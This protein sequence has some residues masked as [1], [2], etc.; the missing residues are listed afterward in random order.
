[1]WTVARWWSE[2]LGLGPA[3]VF[4]DGAIAARLT[5]PSSANFFGSKVAITNDTI[6]VLSGSSDINST[7]SGAFYG[8][9]RVYAKGAGWQ[10]GSSNLASTNYNPQ[11]DDTTFGAT[12]AADNGLFYVGSPGYDG[13]SANTGA[14]HLFSSGGSNGSYLPEHYAGN[15]FYT[16]ALP[17][18]GYGSQLA[19]SDGHLYIGWNNNGDLGRSFYYSVPGVASGVATPLSE[20]LTYSGSAFAADGNTLLVRTT[21]GVRIFKFDA[22]G[23]VAYNEL[24]TGGG[25]N[26]HHD[27]DDGI[28]MLSQQTS[29][30]D[31][32][33]RIAF[34]DYNSGSLQHAIP[35]SELGSVALDGGYAA[36]GDTSGSFPGD[37]GTNVG[38]AYWLVSNSGSGNWS[39]GVQET[40]VGPSA[41]DTGFSFGSDVAVDGNTIAISDPGAGSAEFRDNYG[42]VYI[43]ENDSLAAVLES[44]QSGTSSFGTRLDLS[45]DSLAVINNV[46]TTTTPELHIFERG[47]GWVNGTGNR[48][49]MV[50]RVM[51][52][53]GVYGAFADIAISGNTLAAVAHGSSGSSNLLVWENTA[54]NWQT[55]ISGGL[56]YSFEA[57]PSGS[58]SY[59]SRIQMDGDTIAVYSPQNGYGYSSPTQL[60]PLFVFENTAND[61]SQTPVRTELFPSNLS[62]VSF[63]SVFDVSGN[64]I[65]VGSDTGGT[66]TEAVY[67]FERTTDWASATAPAARLTDSRTGDWGGRVAVDG[68]TVVA[69]GTGGSGAFS[70]FERQSGWQDGDVNLVSTF[71]PN[72]AIHGV[73]MDLSADTLVMPLVA[74]D[75]FNRQ[76]LVRKGPFDITGLNTFSSRP[77][78]S[79]GIAAES[80]SMSLGLGTDITLQ[81]NNDITISNAIIVD[82]PSGNG[83]NLSLHAGR[84]IL[85]N[86]SIDTDN[87]DLTLVA[88]DANANATYRDSGEAVVVIGRD[89][90]NQSVNLT[91]GTGDI[92]IHAA[93]RF[94][95]RSGD[96]GIF[97]FDA[98]TPGRFLV[99]ANSP[100]HTGAPDLANLGEDLA[101]SGRDFVLYNT[102]FNA[103]D[104]APSSLPAGSGFIYSVLPTLNVSVGNDT[105]TYGEVASAPLTLD[106]ITVGGS[107]VSGTVFGI[108]S[109]DLVNLVDTGLAGTVSVGTNTFANAGFY[110]GGITAA[111]KASVTTGS[112]YGVAVVTGAAG[113][114]TVD[115]ATL[116]VRPD[117]AT[118]VYRSADPA[119]TVA[120]TGF[121]TGDDESVIDTDVTVTSAAGITSDIGGY[122]L[123]ATGGFDNNYLFNVTGTGLL[124]IT[125]YDLQITGLTGTDRTYDATT[126]AGF[127]GTA[128]IA[129][130]GGDAVTLAGVLTATASF[131]DKNVGT[132]KALTFSGYS[133]SGAKAGN[134]NL[135]LPAGVTASITPFEL[136]LLGLT[137]L[138]RDYDR[139]TDVTLSGT[140][141]V[142]GFGDDTV[143]VTGSASGAFADKNAGI[144]KTVDIT[145]LALTGA[146]AANYILAADSGVTATINQLGL[147][148]TG[149]TADSRVYDATTVATLS[150]TAAIAPISGDTVSVEGS[151]AANFAD[152]NVG[153]AKP[154]TVSG[155]TITGADA[156]NY[157]VNQPAGLTAD[158]T[159]ADLSITGVTAG[160]RVYDATN[161]AVL[162]GIA[163]VTALGSDEL[164]VGGIG[165]GAFA[166]KNVGTAKDV[167]VTGFTLG[168]G[169]AA[170]YNLLQPA[171]LAADITPRPITVSG[172]VVDHKVYDTTTDATGTGV[173]ALSGVLTGDDA[174]LDGT[175]FAYAFPDKNVGTAKSIVISGVGIAGAD[176]ANYDVTQGDGFTADITPAD[177][178][179]SGAVAS[180][181]EYDSTTAI[182]VSGGTLN[183]VLGSDDIVFETAGATGNTADKN[184]GTAKPVTVT[185]YAVSGAGAGNYL[186]TQPA[187]LTA[188]ITAFTL[189]LAGLTGDKTYDGNTV[190]TLSYSG[191]DAVFTDDVVNIDDAAV[192]GAYADKHAGV[193]KPITITGLYAL[194]GTDAGNYVLAQPT[195]LTGTIAKRG[196]TVSGLTIADKT[197]DATTTGA[198]SGTGTFGGTIEGDDLAIDVGA[199]TVSF[200]DKNAGTD[201]AITLS[202][203]SLTGADADNYSA[204]TPSGITATI[205][206]KDL[207]LT[208]LAAQ[209][210]VYDRTAVATIT[211]T[212]AIQGAISGD[213]VALNESARAGQFADKNAGTAKAVSILGLTLDGVDA[214]NYTIT[215]P[216]LTADITRADVDVTG[217]TA[218]DRI[219]D[220]T[221]VAGLSGT[222]GLDFG[223]LNG[224]LAGA[225]D[226]GLVGTATGSFAD[227][228][229]GVAKAVTVADLTL[230]GADAGNYNLNL[231]AGLTATVS[232]ADLQVTGTTVS[233]KT[234]DATTAG[235][236]VD[237]GTI[238][239]ISGDTVVLGGSQQA[240]FDTKNVGTGKDVALTGYAITGTDAG[241]YNLLQPTG[242]TADITKADL[243]L[244][245]VVANDKIYDG[246]TTAPLGGNLDIAPLGS[247]TVSVTGSPV[248]TFADKNVGTAKAVTLTGLGIAGPDAAN[249]NFVIPSLFAD[250]T[251][252]SVTVSGLT[253]L[254][255]IY[256]GTTIAGLSGAGSLSNGVS[257][258]DLSFDVSA[259][260]GAFA[261]K[262]VGV[263]KSVTLSGN[264]L[265]GA[266]AGNYL[267]VLP[268]DLVADIDPKDLLV[269]GADAVD[270][271]YDRTIEVELTGGTLDGVVT[272][273]DTAL[274]TTAAAGT[275]AD[276]NAGEAKAVTATGYAITGTDAGN[277]TLNQP[278]G[279]DVTIT[280]KE[281]GIAGVEVTDKFFNG[282]TDATI[283]G[284]TL[285]G[286]IAGDDLALVTGNGQGEYIDPEVGLDKPVTLSGFTLSGADAD[287]YKLPAIPETTG[288]ILQPLRVITDVVPA[289]VLR[290]SSNDSVAKQRAALESFNASQNDLVT[291]V[292]YEAF[293]DQVS[294]GIVVTKPIQ[295]IL[296][297]PPEKQDSVTK[298]YIAA[299]TESK[300]ATQ[301][302]QNM[303][304]EYRSFARTY[305][306]LGQTINAVERSLQTEIGLRDTFVA[307][308]ARVDVELAKVNE[309]LTIITEAKRRIE[310]FTQRMAEANRLG[311]GSEAAEYQ[312]VIDEARGI[313]AT[314]TAT[315][316]QKAALEAEAKESHDQ[317]AASDE[318]VAALNTEKSDLTQKIAETETGLANL[319]A[320]A[321]DGKKRAATAAEALAAAQAAG[322]K[323]YAERAANLAAEKAKVEQEVTG[324]KALYESD[325]AATTAAKLVDKDPVVQLY[326]GK[327][328]ESKQVTGT[329]GSALAEN[330]SGDTL[331]YAQKLADKINSGGLLDTA[332]E[333]RDSLVQTVPALKELQAKAD[334]L[335]KLQEDKRA[336]F[337]RRIQLDVDTATLG[338]EV[339]GNGAELSPER[340]AEIAAETRA[341][342]DA[343][344]AVLT[345]GALDLSK[346]PATKADG[347]PLSEME[348][349]SIAIINSQIYSKEGQDQAAGDFAS[350][351]SNK[352]NSA[353]AAELGF[354]PEQA[355]NDPNVLVK[356]AAERLPFSNG[357]LDKDQ[358]ATNLKDTASAYVRLNSVLKDEALNQAAEQDP[359]GSLAAYQNV[360]ASARAEFEK[361]YGAQPEE[362][363]LQ[364][365]QERIDT[366]SKADSPEAFMKLYAEDYIGPGGQMSLAAAKKAY[367][368]IKNGDNPV[369]IIKSINADSGPEG[370]SANTE[371]ARAG[372]TALA[373]RE[374]RDAAIEDADRTGL[375]KSY[376][377]VNG[378]ASEEFAKTFGGSPEE[379]ALDALE[380]PAAAAEKA[381]S[382]AKDVLTTPDGALN[383]GKL[384]IST[385]SNMASATLAVAQQQLDVV[386]AK[387]GGPGKAAAFV[388]KYGI[389][390][391]SEAKDVLQDLG[392]TLTGGLIGKSGPS[393][394][395][396]EN[397]IAYAKAQAEVQAAQRQ[398]DEDDF[399]LSYLAAAQEMAQVKTQ[400]AVGVMNAKAQVGAYV[401]A[402]KQQ[403]D[404]QTYYDT[405]K[406]TSQEALTKV[407]A[408]GIYDNLR[409]ARQKSDELGQSPEE[410]A[411][412]A[413]LWK[414]EA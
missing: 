125:P 314:E 168:G 12:F 11:A 217:L 146:D 323:A 369:D 235:T 187:G 196:I 107:A 10:N 25:F 273:D 197:Y 342:L 274:V 226:I 19:A 263:N 376:N 348:R 231:P 34:F 292:D 71:T 96:T 409:T 377:A 2:H 393:K 237:T 192:T 210:K 266:D 116:N 386:A 316:A 78:D 400:L 230:G 330:L 77:G 159:A 359:T 358:L 216:G 380:N 132:D 135:L 92:I 276:K 52:S 18:A 291:L 363:V 176:A 76:A 385:A 90:L 114:L 186:L 240:V 331:G 167:T 242:V 119:F 344:L 297:T 356:E 68:D 24:N 127:T 333:M 23:N 254:D 26:N 221:T 248:A 153:T 62:D 108:S 228:N 269:I 139:T 355:L 383:V 170:N 270:R 89:S 379:L 390:A 178:S 303:A 324:L 150:G 4:E 351:Y 268:F 322:Q 134:Y 75:G 27:V 300:A 163:G 366:Y 306:E 375:L 82:N 250:I 13:S 101:I 399:L 258:D 371:A 211:G 257:G 384:G 16:N 198:I 308:L 58:T 206:A 42:Y 405:A 46:A 255:R 32:S 54:G 318:K 172:L 262:N 106:S 360:E 289:D 329:L 335:A 3:Y 44:N 56:S 401:V 334:E 194:T 245:N 147:D 161:V 49:A 121:V 347:T 79:V 307:N 144:D 15:S 174:V 357:S 367:E 37:T 173:A 120:Y 396:V 218:L 281:V 387:F 349:L 22:I 290:A 67:V 70:F 117:N 389:S 29:S 382:F 85:V 59:N 9:I 241:N 272:G 213:D 374:A 212:G 299:A 215:D 343:R 284:G 41:A 340:K 81:A 227:K 395:E 65:A 220:S 165:E 31:T 60:D 328:T 123:T 40:K 413:A 354:S 223:A 72:I 305:K 177:L 402:A 271:D 155:Y 315:L 63:G 149:V 246:T 236:I 337:E 55:A 148:V 105:I 50:S 412:Q 5:P 84:N 115:K 229:V 309:N 260:S 279:I 175:S 166:D 103:A 200:A 21:S 302:A 345:G 311:R 126:N 352:V 304:G 1:M 319:K 317:L 410:I 131:A 225:E 51:V 247:D 141:S 301:Y 214:F 232:A 353:I 341:R 156:L 140:A 372:R 277:Y 35:T 14:V 264:G 47:S 179:I 283:S 180:D 361:E 69:Y 152:K 109:S 183:G 293:N 267:Q 282:E 66:N 278:V 137:A 20:H 191:L 251:K 327:L 219:Y 111:A 189:N 98:T 130:L 205:F 129:P 346:V 253:A 285:T 280:P 239:A 157:S 296:D 407:V 17:G 33:K 171:G 53:G 252:R 364:K 95:N 143:A 391:I 99:Y 190:A 136:S 202:G 39:G 397:A 403:A 61:W 365:V 275:V 222:A 118:R 339:F 169:D 124:T 142:N 80:L 122:T 138:E 184:I 188:T 321:E 43:Y 91:T 128:T 112:V 234:Y 294:A 36:Y 362:L 249:Y 102:T 38:G 145:G 94:E 8:A 195:G 162:V 83:G 151:P 265:L 320:A 310:A 93:D 338:L 209:G 336:E 203:V 199:V 207:T 88:D 204:A 326:A 158:I 73:E 30:S 259:I 74:F 286:V 313:V 233:D 411:A 45:G 244:A 6:G 164:T 350:G 48:T 104:I 28:V 261:D 295:G 378:A 287:N 193:A 133:L 406:Q 238:T 154:V 392:S 404:R 182:V 370:G 224:V 398:K 86:A 7:P 288:N 388:A 408:D 394:T 325:V 110:A 256:D 57:R 414:G 368:G 243:A 298:A 160:D 181:R 185:G 201:K 312:K 113:D 208:G 64:T 332:D 97:N 87:G 373:M 100:D 381:K